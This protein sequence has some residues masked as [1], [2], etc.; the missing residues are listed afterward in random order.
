MRS[1]DDRLGLLEAR[2]RD[3]TRSFTALKEEHRLLKD[4]YDV[5]KLKVDW[6]QAFGG[7]L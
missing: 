7:E 1:V 5:L 4:R 6:V 2:L 3:L